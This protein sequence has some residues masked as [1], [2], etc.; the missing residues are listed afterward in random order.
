MKTRS[1]GKKK[2][3]GARAAK[4]PFG[5][6]WVGRKAGKGWKKKLVVRRGTIARLPKAVRDQVNQMMDDGRLCR[7]ILK[8]VKEEAG[9]A[10]TWRMLTDWRKGGYR[11][12]QEQQLRLQDMGAN[13]EFALEVV[14]NSKGK[15]VAEAG[16]EVAAA[17]LYELL[18]EFD[19]AGLKR[20]PT[21]KPEAYPKLV[22]LLTRVSEGGLKFEKHRAEMEKDKAKVENESAAAKPGGVSKDA[23][24]DFRRALRLM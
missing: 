5:L 9:V 13:R 2:G 8:M 16:L 1:R 15:V 7:D 18:N 14:K 20:L 4:N 24:D 6:E 11:D 3:S 17:Q 19:L 23:L 22:G 21:E 10:L 12:W